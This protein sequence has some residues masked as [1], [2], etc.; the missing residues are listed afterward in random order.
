MVNNR[1]TG[2][3]DLKPNS[4][5]ISDG[6]AHNTL[7]EV[8]QELYKAKTANGLISAVAGVAISSTL[9]RHENPARASK[10]DALCM[11]MIDQSGVK[12]AD[13]WLLISEVITDAKAGKYD[14]G[15]P[16][17]TDQV[18]EEAQQKA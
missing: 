11:K 13:E 9:P 15:F 2:K 3:R 6:N 5:A 18:Y 10:L 1:K 4:K 7:T 12:K 17:E 14:A 16:L 8:R